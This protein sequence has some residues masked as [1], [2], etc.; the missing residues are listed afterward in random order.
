MKA[1][2][3]HATLRNGMRLLARRN[4]ANPT[5]S[6]QLAFAAGAVN[7]PPSKSGLAGF[8]KSLLTKGTAK[9]DTAWIAEKIDS[10]GLEI[11]FAS[12]RH[13]LG[14]SAR[15]LVENLRPALA[16]IREVIAEPQPP[17]DELEKMRGRIVTAIRR[18]LDDPATVA[19][20]TLAA[21]IYGP[22]HPYGREPQGTLKSIAAVELEDI[23]A[24]YEAALA[25]GA[26]IVVIVGDIEPNEIEVLV[27]ETLGRWRGGGE[28]KLEPPKDVSLPAEPRR[29]FVAMAEKT[30]SDVALGYQGIRRLDPD[31]HA[32]QV[33]NTVLGRLSLG[34]RVGQRVR[35]REGM[36][37]YAYTG[38]DAGI[39]A[40]PFVFR[41]GVAP[42]N[43]ERAVEIAL[44][45]MRRARD[46]GITAK[47]IED[48][49]L[50]LGGGIARQVETNGGMAS[51]LLSQE[52]FGLGDDYYLRYESILRAL[53]RRDINDALARHLHPD[54]Y[55]LA[56]AG[57]Q[58]K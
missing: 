50:Y 57:P 23:Q 45:E 51:T 58:G 46:K 42:Q 44:D 32:L 40:G 6:I 9:H 53:K 5:V 2:V 25:P 35:D 37:Y 30:Q 14:L 41:A 56:V 48:A 8:A 16:L 10:L 15:V 17:A 3:L 13:T 55:C 27:A 18:R 24:F 28:F 19:G 29:K 43:V 47:E 21:M 49:V 4:P 31:Y 38:F 22:R 7:D 1:D 12:G 52:I 36:A 20:E 11:G 26:A 39:G 54:N 34:G 33:G